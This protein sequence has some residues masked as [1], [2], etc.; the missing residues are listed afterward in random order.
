MIHNR[1]KQLSYIPAYQEDMFL[2][3]MKHL[4]RGSEMSQILFAWGKCRKKDGWIVS[5]YRNRDDSYYTLKV[6]KADARLKDE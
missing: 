3:N 1:Y 4:D 6:R 2:H 5:K